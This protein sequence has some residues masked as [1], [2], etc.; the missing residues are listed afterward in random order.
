MLQFAQIFIAILIIVLLVPQTSTVNYT[1]RK[2]YESG[3]FAFWSGAKRF[4][5][6]LTWGTIFAFFLITYMSARG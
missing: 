3:I 4:V 2:F 5:T 6:Q 1:L